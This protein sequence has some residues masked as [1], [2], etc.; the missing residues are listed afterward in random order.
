MNQPTLKCIV[1][2]D[3]IASQKVIEHFISET[4]VLIHCK[5]FLNPKEAYKYLQLN[6]SIDLIFLDINMPEQHGLE[7]YK[8]LSSAPPVIF[9]TAYPQYAVEGFNVNAIDYLLKPIPYERFL[10][11]IKKVLDQRSNKKR[12]KTFL[13]IKENKT[14]HKV[15]PDAIIYVEAASDY[16]KVF[17]ADRFILT[18]STFSSFIE[19]LPDS[20]L[21]IHKSYCVNTEFI[22]KLS[23]NRIEVSNH[24]LPIGQTYKSKVL[25][26]LNIE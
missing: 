21:R 3:E 14:I 22:S 6:N 25:N 15:H 9:T 24:I 2:D 7:F 18:H 19:S 8:S 23:G 17:T 1:I 11:A 13:T 12:E 20:F 26:F 16:V 5:S 4:E 10:K